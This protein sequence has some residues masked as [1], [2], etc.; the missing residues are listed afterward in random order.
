MIK[1]NHVGCLCFDTLAGV[2][3]VVV[4]VKITGWRNIIVGVTDPAKSN[5]P[6]ILRLIF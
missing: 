6:G 1:F 4:I 2:G 3:V 5:E